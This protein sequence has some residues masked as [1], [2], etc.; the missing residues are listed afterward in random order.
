MQ[1]KVTLVEHN[2]NKEL[3]ASNIIQH[4]YM[5]KLVHKTSKPG[6]PL[7]KPKPDSTPFGEFPK[8]YLKGKKNRRKTK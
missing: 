5:K 6:K 1:P 2:L 4:D 8:E 3:I 7:N